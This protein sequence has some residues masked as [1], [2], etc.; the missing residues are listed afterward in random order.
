MSRPALNCQ[1]TR[2][3]R[4]PMGWVSRSRRP[5]WMETDPSGQPGPVQI[6]ADKP[7]VQGGQ[8]SRAEP[9]TVQTV[10]VHCVCTPTAHVLSNACRHTT[11]CPHTAAVRCTAEQASTFCQCVAGRIIRTP[12][13]NHHPTP[14]TRSPAEA[15]H[16]TAAGHDS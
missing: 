11:P 13:N 6:V 10:V 8:Q 14:P 9:H 16:G 12:I 2:R 5:R 15:L 4:Q 7:A 1:H 3:S